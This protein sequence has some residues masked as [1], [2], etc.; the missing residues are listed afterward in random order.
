MLEFRV[1]RCL[2][3]EMKYD[4]EKLRAREQ[5][6]TDTLERQWIFDREIDGGSDSLLCFIL[7]EDYTAREAKDVEARR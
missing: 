6:L 3:S 4:I 1:S 5:L 2:A 7:L